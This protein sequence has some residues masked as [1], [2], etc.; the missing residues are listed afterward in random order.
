MRTCLRVL[1]E[2][3]VCTQGVANHAP[4][5]TCFFKATHRSSRS[6]QYSL[7]VRGCGDD[8]LHLKLPDGRGHR[9]QFV[10]GACMTS[11]TVSS[12][13]P[14]LSGDLS[15]P[16]KG[17]GEAMPCHGNARKDNFSMIRR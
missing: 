17:E 9:P 4:P 6:R 8:K 5:L 14:C 10:S 3:C 11:M 2:Y 16:R 15:N 13:A 1:T 12:T 7:A